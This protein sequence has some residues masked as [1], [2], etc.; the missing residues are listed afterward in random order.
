[1]RTYDV[2]F[3]PGGEIYNMET[4]PALA[5]PTYSPVVA[6]D[7]SK[8]ARVLIIE[9]DEA[10][11]MLFSDLLEEPEP[12]EY[13]IAVDHAGS[14]D[15]G[16]AR[17]SEA[18][19]DAVLLDL[20]LPDSTGLQ[21]IDAFHDAFPDIPVA[22]LTA[23]DDETLSKRAVEHGAQVY[24]FKGSL[25]GT[26]LKDAVRDAI[27]RKNLQI[28][29]RSIQPYID[30]VSA[31]DTVQAGIQQLMSKL[32]A[33]T[34]WDYAEAWVA[35]ADGKCLGRDPNWCARVE[36]LDEFASLSQHFRFPIGEGLAG[37][38]AQTGQMIWVR[39]VTREME[40]RRATLARQA[41]L[42]SAAFLPVRSGDDIVAILA[43]F[44]L[45]KQ[46]EE[47]YEESYEEPNT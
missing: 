26:H 3:V 30:A 17:L 15:E 27:E 22:V 13:V 7:S 43:I 32:C 29:L 16:L 12:H 1:V 10:Q 45:R 11:A 23:Y 47:T 36:G 40:F 5:T 9:D 28:E 37:R 39:D 4:D 14:L 19:Y 18:E 31:A 46:H 33:A 38:V 25:Y 42:E 2:T 20:S 34:S 35:S 41:G 24:V 21:T 8:T 6:S 44:K